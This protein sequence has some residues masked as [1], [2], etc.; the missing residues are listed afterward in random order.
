MKDLSV[1][2][3]YL[4]CILNERGTLPALRA[5]SQVCLLAGGLI[6]LILAKSVAVGEDKKLRITAEL[7]AEHQHLK[8]LYM[9]IKE[10]KAMKVDALASEYAF[11]FS[12]KRFKLLLKDIGTSL[13]DLEYASVEQGRLFG[14]TTCFIPDKNSVDHV[15]QTIRAELL[16]EGT[17]SDPIIALVSLLY[18]SNQIKKYFS[19]YEKEQLNVRLKEM[20]ENDSNKLLNEMLEWIDTLIAVIAAT[21]AAH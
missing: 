13:V 9:F 3:R 8:S 16:E 6:D 15:I 4:I 5:D 20:K 7:T 10:S 12:D 19:K 18:K 2:Q 17:V 1:S 21:S 14:K 11:T